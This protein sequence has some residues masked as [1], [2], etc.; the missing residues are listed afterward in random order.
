MEHVPALFIKSV[1]CLSSLSTVQP[2]KKLSSLP[3]SQLAADQMA[4]RKNWTLCIE[5]RTDRFFGIFQ[6]RSVHPIDCATLQEFARKDPTENQITG[7]ALGKP[8]HMIVWPVGVPSQWAELIN[9]RD[10]KSFARR[11]FPRINYGALDLLT[12]KVVDSIGLH[13]AIL[14]HLADKHPWIKC[15]KLTYEGPASTVLLRRLVQKNV[16]RSMYIYGGWPPQSTAP[17]VEALIPQRQLRKL[18]CCV[19]MRLSESFLT[20]LVAD[21]CDDN[22]PEEKEVIIWGLQTLPLDNGVYRH[23]NLKDKL[24]VDVNSRFIRLQF[25][26]FINHSVKLCRIIM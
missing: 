10:I 24:E 11:I 14:H 2:V 15:L 12:L 1:L 3:W 23:M 7:I 4:R 8:E 6:N 26:R 5:D 19:R 18:H 20:S 22:S 25:S 16:I 13:S 9:G 17:L 21:W